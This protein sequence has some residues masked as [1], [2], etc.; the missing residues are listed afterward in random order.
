[1]VHSPLHLNVHRL[2]PLGESSRPRHVSTSALHSCMP[3]ALP[4][5][6]TAR[7]AIERELGRG[8][9]GAV[10]LARDRTLDRHVALKV[11]P[12]EIASDT[13]LRDRFLRETR[14]AASFSHPNI[15]PVYAVEQHDGVLAYA[16]G[17]IDG[18]SLGAR[19]AR[20]GPLPVRDVVKLLQDVCYAL[21]YAHGRDIVHRDLKPDNIMIER[22]TGRALLMDFGVARAITSTRT[23]NTTAL[24]RVGEVVGTPE[25]MSPEQAAGDVV[26]GRSDLYALGLVAYFALTGTPVFS[27]GSTQQ[28]IVKQL[29]EAPPPITTLRADT[30][31]S[32]AELIEQCVR[33]E[34][35][36]RF[37]NA[38]AVLDALDRAQISGPQI[39]L[40]VRL[41]VQDVSTMAIVFLFGMLLIVT[42]GAAI[43]DRSLREGF[44]A[45]ADGFIP[46][47]VL[48]AV[49]LTRAFQL[50]ADGRRLRQEGFTRDD[51]MGAVRT[52]REERHERRRQN[53]ANPDII[54]RRRQSVRT[55][56]V[57]IAI[58]V[59]SGLYAY[60]TRRP[61][62][63][64]SFYT[65]PI[66]LFALFTA[67][68]CF[69]A[70]FALLVN[71][72]LREPM[73]E[74]TQAALWRSLLGRGFLRIAMGRGT[75]ASTV[76][77]ARTLAPRPHTIDARVKALESRV[78]AL[79]T[80]KP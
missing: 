78:A 48:F 28:L 46:L 9:M 35:A 49:L 15:V 79:E 63:A 33:K 4:D 22:A 62:T 75:T 18:E 55:A 53:L 24:T 61:L 34:P 70:G 73:A 67:L 30:P 59:A 66:G 20:M 1:M 72:P 38:G 64:T 50:I 60:S 7:Y 27:G 12:P 2:A 52:T 29:T 68:G 71:S 13:A 44:I 3:A 58:G 47:V 42:Q 36:E 80:R 31:S 74:K 25:Y 10:Y 77:T 37:A 69:G 5:A 41:Y 45:H 32:L 17:F 21:A 51:V 76:T 65:P 8:G 14:V 40:P 23:A 43:L 11:L 16:M 57:T 54:A 26:D 39:P 56:F 6:L 19:V